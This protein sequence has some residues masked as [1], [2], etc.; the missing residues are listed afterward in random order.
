MRKEDKQHCYLARDLNYSMKPIFKTN[1]F[2]HLNLKWIE[3]LLQCMIATAV[4][5]GLHKKVVREDRPHKEWKATEE[6]VS[7]LTASDYNSD[8][9]RIICASSFHRMIKPFC[10]KGWAIEGALHCNKVY[11]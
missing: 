10:K 4:K 3:A 7:Y 11:S 1:Y 8:E 9:G 6:K 5:E 2:V